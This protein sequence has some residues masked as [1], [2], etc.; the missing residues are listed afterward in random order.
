MG[1]RIAMSACGRSSTR[2]AGDVLVG[3]AISA[4]AFSVHLA[5]PAL[6]RS[7]WLWCGRIL[8]RKDATE[9]RRLR[10]LYWRIFHSFSAPAALI[11]AQ[12]P[13]RARVW[14]ESL[15]GDEL[16]THG[17]FRVPYAKP[18]WEGG[19]A[20][21]VHVVDSRIAAPWMH[22]SNTGLIDARPGRQ[23][24]RRQLK[25]LMCFVCRRFCAMHA[26]SLEA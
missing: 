4:S 15:L 10:I 6:G 3:R 7:V 18:N 22:A 5:A 16:R 13:R 9:R 24:Q 19:Q 23:T 11:R 25:E 26:P 17:H 12:E 14:I 8:G 2:D 1:P 21:Q 20:R